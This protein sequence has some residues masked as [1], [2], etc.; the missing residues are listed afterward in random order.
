MLKVIP[1]YTY[2]DIYF[3]INYADNEKVSVDFSA[4]S[5]YYLDMNNG[6]MHPMVSGLNVDRDNGISF[7]QLFGPGYSGAGY[8]YIARTIPSGAPERLRFS[9]VDELGHH[10]IQVYG[11]SVYLS[12]SRNTGFVLLAPG[13]SSAAFVRGT[14]WS[15]RILTNGGDPSSRNVKENFEDI[16]DEYK[17]IYED[18]KTLHMYNY[19]YKYKNVSGDLEKDYGFIID[20]IE[21]TKHLS[22]YFRKRS[23]KNWNFYFRSYS[24]RAF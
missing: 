6:S 5:N 3:N 24:K 1:F 14:D 12:A 19:D 23:S 20:D 15:Q 16:E 21:D 4:Y 2:Y 13:S 18:L 10:D 7:R 9:S 22:K 11:Q 17:D 8:G